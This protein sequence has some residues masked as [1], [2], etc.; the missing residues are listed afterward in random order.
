MPAHAAAVVVAVVAGVAALAAFHHFVYEPHIAPTLEAWAEDFVA[1]RRAAR[2]AVPIPT[3]TRRRRRRRQHSPSSSS[4]P[5]SRNSSPATSGAHGSPRV[6][7]SATRTRRATRR[8]TR[9]R[10]RTGRSFDD[11]E[12]YELEGLIANDVEEWRNEVRRS[13][14]E[15]GL[16]RRRGFGLGGRMNNP[17]DHDFDHMSTTLD[18]SFTEL[19]HTPIA[20]TH[21]ISNVSSPISSDTLSLPSVPHSPAPANLSIRNRSGSTTTITATAIQGQELHASQRTETLATSLSPSVVVL[22]KSPDETTEP[23]T[24]TLPPS[25]LTSPRLITIPPIATPPSAFGSPPVLRSCPGYTTVER[26]DDSPFG[27]LLPDTPRS[28]PALYAGRPFSPI[29]RLP[30]SASSPTAPG[31]EIANAPPFS[32]GSSFGR[33]GSALVHEISRAEE[34]G[35]T[36]NIESPLSNNNAQPGRGSTPVHSP[37]RSPRHNSSPGR[38]APNTVVQPLDPDYTDP[39]SSVASLSLRYPVPPTSPVMVS[40]PPSEGVRSWSSPSSPRSSMSPPTSEELR[41]LSSLSSKG[42]VSPEWAS[43]PVFAS[44]ELVLS[45]GSTSPV[46]VPSSPVAIPSSSLPGSASVVAGLSSS[47]STLRVPKPSTAEP[48]SGLEGSSP[49]PSSPTTSF[50]SFASFATPASVVR[51]VSAVSDDRDID[52]LSAA[53]SDGEDDDEGRMKNTTSRVPLPD[54]AYNP[55]LDHEEVFEVGSDGSDG[56][57]HRSDESGSDGSWGSHGSAELH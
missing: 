40:P 37:I 34:N 52:F 49:I 45:S 41:S 56:D 43:S 54:R 10:G 21:V 36:A 57:D 33:R 2:G 44:P 17:S 39:N 19:T 3:P 30:G 20:P 12:S 23:D 11:A 51:T 38:Q 31:I 26:D 53:D 8:T 50:A 25:S 6:D 1:R 22:P 27:P 7:P 32:R 29:V 5:N 13:Q 9:T 35:T 28:S 15:A 47:A 24:D 48:R 42:S 18:E 46:L 55:F 16:R 14:G 4:S